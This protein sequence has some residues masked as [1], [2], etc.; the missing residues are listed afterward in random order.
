MFTIDQKRLG[1]NGTERY[2]ISQELVNA[3]ERDEMDVYYQPVV[4]LSTGTIVGVEALLRWKHFQKGN[5]PPSVFIPIA[6]EFGLIDAIGQWS[7]R[8]ACEDIVKL[9]RLGRKGLKVAVN[10]SALQMQ[11]KQFPQRI[12]HILKETEL[13][14]KW[15]SLELTESAVIQDIEL[16]ARNLEEIRAM[17]IQISI[18]DFGTG[19]SSLH[20]LKH[21]PVDHIKIDKSF[22]QSGQAEDVAIV[23]GIITI[24]RHLHLQVVAEGVESA[25]HLEFL[26][27]NGCDFYQGYFTSKPL[28]LAQM[29][30]LIKENE[31][32]VHF[33]HTGGQKS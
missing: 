4:E 11:D 15:L 16:T 24:A 30:Q 32:V 19:Y 3:C 12:Q 21:F 23:K 31:D 1:T 17:G 28:P 22:V 26:R 5:I 9:H 29:N 8:R 6:E 25:E 14:G 10:V 20:Y 27:Q 33:K 13:D 18:D 7:L 2:F